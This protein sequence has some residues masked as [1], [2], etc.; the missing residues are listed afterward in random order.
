MLPIDAMIR[1]SFS[2]PHIRVV[3]AHTGCSC[4]FPSVSADEPVDYYQGMFE[5]SSNRAEDLESVR[6]LLALIRKHAVNGNRVE[7]FPVWFTDQAF[8]PKGTIHVDAGSLEP[9]TF[10]FNEDFF[11]VVRGGAA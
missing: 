4:G 11:Y 7:I 2:L 9:E 8:P 3:G 1:P 5:D 10:F 6:A